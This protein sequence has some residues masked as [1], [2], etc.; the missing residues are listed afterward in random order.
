MPSAALAPHSATPCMVGRH[1]ESNEEMWA[2]SEVPLQALLAHVD[3]YHPPQPLSTA[4]VVTGGKVVFTGDYAGKLV[5]WVGL[6]DQQA[7]RWTRP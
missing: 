4:P 7:A 6:T 5:T 1:P 3:R 2:E